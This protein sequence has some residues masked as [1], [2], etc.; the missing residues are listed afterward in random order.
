MST[1]YDQLDTLLNKMSA[2]NEDLIDYEEDDLAVTPAAPATNGA[3]AKTAAAA[4][5]KD[6]KGSYVGIHSVRGSRG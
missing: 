2:E 5:S 6:Q 3:G 4:E 1:L